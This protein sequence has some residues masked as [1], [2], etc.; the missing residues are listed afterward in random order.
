MYDSCIDFFS[1]YFYWTLH[2]ICQ[3]E[4]GNCS[5]Q[6]YLCFHFP[7]TALACQPI[8][9]SSAHN[10]DTSYQPQ[11][12]L[13]F[14]LREMHFPGDLVSFQH[15]LTLAVIH[16]KLFSGVYH[17]DDTSYTSHLMSPDFFPLFRYSFVTMLMPFSTSYSRLVPSTRSSS[18][19]ILLSGHILILPALAHSSCLL[20]SA[21]FPLG[22]C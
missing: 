16:F 14:Y 19:V 22:W 1:T 2:F 6:A 17:G 13:D 11:S 15:I 21:D 20:P 4:D 5:W 18:C 10:L 7:L 8:L 12:L 3:C 9:L